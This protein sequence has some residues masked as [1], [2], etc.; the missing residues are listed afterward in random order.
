MHKTQLD[1]CLGSGMASPSSHPGL[2]LLGAQCSVFTGF[3]L[4]SDFWLLVC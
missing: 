2:S 4:F 1:A 3:V